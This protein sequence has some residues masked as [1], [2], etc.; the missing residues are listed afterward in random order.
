M[1]GVQTLLQ[2]LHSRSEQISDCGERAK[3]ITMGEETVTQKPKPSL[4]LFLEIADSSG[5]LSSIP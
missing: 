5:D 4:A 3:G 2:E 1:A